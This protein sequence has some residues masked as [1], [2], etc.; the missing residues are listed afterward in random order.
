VPRLQGSHRL[1]VGDGGLS[2]ASV[3]FDVDELTALAGDLSKAAATAPVKAAVVV[4][5]A[6]VDTQRDAQAFCP[7][8]TVNLR[9]SIET[10]PMGPLAAEIGPTASYG[11]FVEFGTSR[12]GPQPYLGP[13]LDRNTPAFLAAMEQ[14]AGGLL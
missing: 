4:Q 2:V 8:D 13:G 6:A 10:E 1:I 7:V 5:K 3:W 14:V 9:A 11:H 12:M